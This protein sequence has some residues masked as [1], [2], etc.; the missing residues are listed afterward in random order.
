MAWT[1][2]DKTAGICL[3]IELACKM[4]PEEV[5][6]CL[7]NMGNIVSDRLDLGQPAPPTK[8]PELTACIQQYMKTRKN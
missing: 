3:M 4:K 8:H 7:V 1:T 2:T 6:Q 5:F